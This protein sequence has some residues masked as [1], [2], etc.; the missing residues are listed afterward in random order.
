MEDEWI[1]DIEASRHMTPNRKYFHTYKKMS[2]CRTEVRKESIV[3]AEGK[4]TILIN[5]CINRKWLDESMS[6]VLH[7]PGHGGMFMVNYFR[8]E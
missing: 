2:N 4:G 7:V 5:R 8:K 3:K 1:L 6:E